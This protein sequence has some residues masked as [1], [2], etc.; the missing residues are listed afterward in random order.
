MD[1]FD[2]ELAKM[3]ADH[4]AGKKIEE[5]AYGLLCD[6]TD[7]MSFPVEEARKITQT[8]LAFLKKINYTVSNEE[9][10]DVVSAIF[11]CQE[12]EVAVAVGKELGVNAEL[13]SRVVDEIIATCIN[14]DFEFTTITLDN[15]VELCAWTNIAAP[16]WN[17]ER[18]C[19][20]VM[21]A[22]ER[23]IH[24]DCVRQAAKYLVEWC[25]EFDITLLDFVKAAEPV[26]KDMKTDDDG[27]EPAAVAYVEG[28]IANGITR[29]QMIN[30]LTEAGMLENR[31]I[32]LKALEKY[33]N[34]EFE[35][36]KD[37][38]DDDHF[39]SFVSIM[40]L[41]SPSEL[42]SDIVQECA[43]RIIEDRYCDDVVDQDLAK[44][45]LSLHQLAGERPNPRDETSPPRSIEIDAIVEEGLD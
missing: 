36:H 17:E 40:A 24:H 45:G 38:L 35:V 42:G 39:V 4:A 29:Q 41:T 21:T 44:F 22:V 31:W 34:Y 23:E 30:R 3:R 8:T 37:G 18:I 32:G 6:A 2:R 28:H 13:W 19:R 33:G 12:V 43:M 15:L 27:V 25:E 1:S 5:A 14:G 26:C 20:A 9:T 7:Y 10:I 16:Q 11:R